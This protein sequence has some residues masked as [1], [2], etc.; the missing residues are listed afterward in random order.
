MSQPPPWLTLL[1]DIH[2]QQQ[3]LQ[4]TLCWLDEDEYTQQLPSTGQ[5]P[6]QLIEV[7][8]HHQLSIVHE[9]QKYL[10]ETHDRTPALRLQAE[11]LPTVWA[12][13]W[14]FFQNR[15]QE[16]TAAHLPGSVGDH[17]HSRCRQLL[18][19]VT[20]TRRVLADYWYSLP[21][22]GQA[23]L[24]G[25]VADQFDILLDGVGGLPE[26]ALCTDVIAGSWTAREILVHVLIWE[27]YG[28]EILRQWP[29]PDPPSLRPWQ[30]K[31]MNQANQIMLE[32]RQHL[33]LIDVLGDL[34][35][36]RRRT[37]RYIDTSSEAK[38]I[39]TG[40]YGEDGEG[41]LA[42]FLLQMAQHR[43]EHAQAIWAAREAGQLT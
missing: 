35:T 4:E 29:R 21:R 25:F 34:Y 20:D 15:V 3:H 30:Y 14:V 6:W 41:S 8:C 31:D 23:R 5:S 38:L 1:D 13:H 16:V 12:Q 7:L 19:Q 22:W 17:M 39:S 33:S 37:L 9:V 27:E 11:D 18:A 24:R 40:S 32:A 10:Q 26:E 43:N 36:Y 42:A 28:W 2:H